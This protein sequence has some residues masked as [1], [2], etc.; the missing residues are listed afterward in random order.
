MGSKTKAASHQLFTLVTDT[1]NVASLVRLQHISISVFSSVK[2]Q[3]R[4][5]ERSNSKHG[6]SGHI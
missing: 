4:R 1:Q 6:S 3:R 5:G 2:S